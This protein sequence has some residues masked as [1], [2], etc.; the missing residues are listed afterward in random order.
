MTRLVWLQNKSVKKSCSL[1]GSSAQKSSILPLTDGLKEKE[2]QVTRLPGGFPGAS[3]E[4][5]R[6]TDEA[7]CQLEL[8]LNFDKD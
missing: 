8:C 4:A 3:R 6:A 7:I 5:L 1:I 2:C